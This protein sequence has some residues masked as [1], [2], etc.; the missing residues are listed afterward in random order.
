MFDSY[1][2][3]TTPSALSSLKGPAR[4]HSVPGV[5]SEVRGVMLSNVRKLIKIFHFL[6]LSSLP[7][8]PIPVLDVA[9]YLTAFLCFNKFQQ[10]PYMCHIRNEPLSVFVTSRSPVSRVTG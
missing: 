10:F 4:K 1:G 2:R 6:I 3:L 7:S 9:A 5:I 8:L